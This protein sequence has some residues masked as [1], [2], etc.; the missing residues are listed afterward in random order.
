LFALA[1]DLRAESSK[2]KARSLVPRRIGV[3]TKRRSTGLSRPPNEQA[4]GTQSKQRR[5]SRLRRA[6]GLQ[7]IEVM[8]LAFPFRFV[9]MLLSIKNKLSLIRRRKVCHVVE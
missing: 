5:C 9:N 7:V 3:E 4:Q 8:E 1:D 2:Q 6:D